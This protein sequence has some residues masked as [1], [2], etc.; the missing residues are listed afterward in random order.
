[1]IKNNFYHVHNNKIGFIETVKDIDFLKNVLKYQGQIIQSNEPIQKLIDDR[2]IKIEKGYKY[3]ADTES[4]IPM[5]EKEKVDAK[6][7][8]L[9][10]YKSICHAK[11]KSWY[12]NIKE[13]GVQ[14][15]IYSDILARQIDCNADSI[16]VAERMVT[17]GKINSKFAPTFYK[18]FDNSTV[19]CTYEQWVGVYSELHLAGLNIW[20]KQNQGK[21][22]LKN[23]KTVEEIET[24]MSEF[25]G[26]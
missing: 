21:E 14:G 22:A 13:K 12:E 1:M 4:I 5:S 7:I 25:T 3:D 9:D 17:A 16:V 8:T 6:I 24:I 15:G 18:C 23:A 11:I 20:N 2:T 26:E 19:D 10:S